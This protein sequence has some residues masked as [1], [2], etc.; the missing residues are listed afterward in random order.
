MPKNRYVEV[1]IPLYYEGH[2]YRAGS[3]SCAACAGDSGGD[4][5]VLLR[6]GAGAL[7]ITASVDAVIPGPRPERRPYP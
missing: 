3:A 6:P 5:R 4:R 7:A 2:V 1:T